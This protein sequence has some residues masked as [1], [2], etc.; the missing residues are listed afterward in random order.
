MLSLEGCA[1]NESWG[2]SGLKVQ[3][4][5]F[6][7]RF[8]SRIN[9][10]ACYDVWGTST[11]S[12]DV[13]CLANL[14]INVSVLSFQSHV[15]EQSPW[16]AD[17]DSLVMKFPVLHL[18]GE[19]TELC[20]SFYRIPLGRGCFTCYSKERLYKSIICSYFTKALRL[21]VVKTVM[22]LRVPW[23]AGDVLT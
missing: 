3:K 13:T 15:M 7:H 23:K 20:K 4:S 17:S 5:G 11:S 12:G 10:V 9:P 21:A 1:R 6:R 19:V 14:C 2:S 18:R 8:S 16:D 22:N